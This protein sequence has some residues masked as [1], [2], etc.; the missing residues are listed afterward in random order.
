MKKTYEN[1]AFEMAHEGCAECVELLK[2]AEKAY[3]PRVVEQ[4]T[5]YSET[6]WGSVRFSA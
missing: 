5:T 1:T 2:E 6:C 3:K 4:A